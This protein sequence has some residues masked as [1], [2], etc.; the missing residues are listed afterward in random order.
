[1][2]YLCSNAPDAD[3]AGAI[4]II[5]NADASHAAELHALLK[6]ANHPLYACD[7]AYLAN[8]TMWRDRFLDHQSST[9]CNV[10][11]RTACS[12]MMQSRRNATPSSSSSSTSI[13][14]APGNKVRPDQHPEILLSWRT[15]VIAWYFDYIHS[16]NYEFNTAL[17]ALSYLDVYSMS[18]CFPNEF[19]RILGDEETITTTATN[20]TTITDDVGCISTPSPSKKSKTSHDSRYEVCIEDNDNHSQR[21]E[22]Q[23]CDDS[24]HGLD[25][26]QYRLAAVAS[27]YLACKVFQSTPTIATSTGFAN[28]MGDGTI[29]SVQIEDMELII[30]K[31]LRFRVHTPTS[32]RFIH[33]LLPLL[34]PHRV[35]NCSS[36]WAPQ[37]DIEERI[38]LDAVMLATLASFCG[39]EKVS[40]I[41]SASPPKIAL[42]AIIEASKR[43]FNRERMIFARQA[44]LEQLFRQQVI[45]YDDEVRVIQKC[46]VELKRLNEQKSKDTYTAGNVSHSTDTSNPSGTN[47]NSCDITDNFQYA[48]TSNPKL[49]NTND[50]TTMYTAFRR[51]VSQSSDAES[52]MIAYSKCSDG[53]IHR[54]W[55][56]IAQ[57][58]SAANATSD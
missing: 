14:D 55:D 45:P 16:R 24:I 49:D 31:L 38:V 11:S 21:H 56:S 26:V 33:E 6:R 30:L 17:V 28:A 29:S 50:L 9:K 48:C 54:V 40:A 53:N 22:R 36:P 44:F 18:V 13:L 7:R 41:V 5:E 10:E 46:L 4:T 27:L 34:I 42:A 37:C 35:R 15:R 2:S 23:Q 20:S 1:M 43:I 58:V 25:I 8:L 19:R 52:P 12:A 32:L 39:S 47:V 57:C 51:T 3:V